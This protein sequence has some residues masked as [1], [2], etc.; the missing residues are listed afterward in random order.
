MTV[1][2]S[3]TG[4]ACPTPAAAASS[5]VDRPTSPRLMLA[6]RGD[7]LTRYL[8][9]ALGRRFPVAGQ[10]SVD[11]TPTQRYLT[12]ASTFRPSRTAW[13]ERF[14]KSALA[15]R[16][17]SANAAR[18]VAAQ[19]GD[20]DVLFQ[21]HALFTSSAPNTTLYIDCTHRQSA[22]HWPEWNP[23]TGT[24]LA[25]WYT[26]E[27][28]EYQRAAHL[29]AF[30]EPTRRS[31]IDQ[32]GVP[33]QRVTVVGAGACLDRLPDLSRR[34]DAPTILFVGNDF[35]RKGG[36]VLL[37]A[38]RLVRQE[39]PAATL[40]LV[41]S[42]PGRINQDGVFVHGRIHDR[43]RLEALYRSASVFTVPSFFDPF[44][45]VLLEAMAYGLPTV[46]SFS[47][48]I[49]EIIDDGRTGILVDAG[50]PEQLAGALISYL[51]DRDA[52]DRAGRAGRA[53]VEA[54]YTWD[55]VVERMTPALQSLRAT[56]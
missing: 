46:A 55:A 1:P 37:E 34:P 32:Y 48:G 56:G 31:L 53:K 40:H 51:T 50:N 26:R 17:R 10:V 38:F 2:N 7:A 21:I 42:D 44:P 19:N 24:E 15:Y 47:C 43:T 14:Y 30:C 6:S 11:L 4:D 45:L 52:A 25:A 41:G 9:R 29:F 39:I 16:L 20:Y 27:R 22:D 35:V 18:T 8:F 54:M 12:A 33:E 13:V 36:L 23:L 5:S 28:A 49:P 3:T